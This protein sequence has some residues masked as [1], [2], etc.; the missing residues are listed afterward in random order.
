[1]IQNQ[2]LIAEGQRG[3]RR[4]IVLG[5]TMAELM[6]LLLFC[7]LLVSAS[8]ML[9]KQNELEAANRRVAELERVAVGNMTADEA[10]ALR[11]AQERLTG[12]LSVLFPDGIPTMSTAQ[13]DELWRE[14][15]L[16]RDSATAMKSA[17]LDSS[18]KDIAELAR[19]SKTLE[20]S[21]LTPEQLQQLAD[22]IAHPEK[23]PTMV[24]HTWPPII[25]L[26]DDG[27]RFEVG[28]AEIKP[29]FQSSLKSDVADSVLKLLKTYNVNVIEII[30]HTDEQRI[31]PTRPSNLDEEA[32]LA[33]QGKF[34]PDQLIPVDNAGLGLARAIAV[35]NALKSTGEFDNFK[36][37]PLSAAQLVLPGDVLSDGT[38]IGDDRGRRRIEIRVRRTTGEEK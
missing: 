4:G 19:I 33:A 30:G 15:R 22:A 28:S 14:L 16:A 25:S 26:N 36:I 21:A 17:G 1:M 10:L 27:N 7:L 6:L 24:G 8:G 12:L 38:S 35:A 9:K 31:Y 11:V 3:H 37:V 32:I 5:F 34:S 13:V 29:A 18:S 23:N 2:G 20:T